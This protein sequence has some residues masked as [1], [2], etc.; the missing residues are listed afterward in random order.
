VTTD[1]VPTTEAEGVHRRRMAERGED[2]EKDAGDGS[3]ARRWRPCAVVGMRAGRVLRVC[4]TVWKGEREA[5]MWVNGTLQ[6]ARHISSYL[7][8]H[9]GC[10]IPCVTEVYF[11]VYMEK[12]LLNPLNYQLV[13]NLRP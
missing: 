11:T 6:E 7:F 10:A 9:I 4:V 13:S 8:Q 2:R 12:S 3:C 1:D 5:S